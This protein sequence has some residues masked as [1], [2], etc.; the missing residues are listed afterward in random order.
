M[1]TNIITAFALLLL[2]ASCQKEPVTAS[3]NCAAVI[4][5]NA[6]AFN[7]LTSSANFNIQDARI[8]GNTLTLKFAHGGGC[9]PDF[10]FQLHAN[11]SIADFCGANINAKVIFTTN[12]GC[13]R[14]DYTERC[15]DIST[16]KT[17]KGCQDKLQIDGYPTIISLY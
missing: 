15:F 8:S 16:L 17:R 4:R 1:K 12:S 7:Q 5:D 3:E 10:K 11:P 14:L 9:D 13:K 6:T 2:A